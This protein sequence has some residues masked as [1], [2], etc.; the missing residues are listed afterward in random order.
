MEK[1]EGRRSVILCDG[2]PLK[3]VKQ[4]GQRQNADIV[5]ACAIVAGEKFTSTSEYLANLLRSQAKLSAEIK[6]LE[7]EITKHDQLTEA[8]SI[9]F[10][11]SHVRELI[12][13]KESDVPPVFTI[14]DIDDLKRVNDTYGHPAGNTILSRFGECVRKNIYEEDPFGRL[15]GDEFGI[16][17]Q[18]ARIEVVQNI[19]EYIRSQYE[20]IEFDFNV[21]RSG[22][23]HPS[24]SYGVAVYGV[25]GWTYEELFAQADARM[26]IEKR[27]RKCTRGDAIIS[28]K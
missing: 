4:C 11:I 26:Y 9:T 19:I 5:C 7:R 6:K 16:L 23:I 12:A 24:F 17:F 22:E 3:A 27:A 28:R 21:S 15:G 8:L 20:K 1:T 2:D 25:D 14:I 10:F 13:H 18:H